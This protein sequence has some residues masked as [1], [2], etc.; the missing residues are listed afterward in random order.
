MACSKQRVLTF[1]ETTNNILWHNLWHDYCLNI[2]INLQSKVTL[3][4]K[5]HMKSVYYTDPKGDNPG[6]VLDLDLDKGRLIAI[7]VARTHLK[8][9]RSGG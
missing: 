5:A 2:Y 4:M 8:Y 6:A 7:N 3:F 1:F 9:F